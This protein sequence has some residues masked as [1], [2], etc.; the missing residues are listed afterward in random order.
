MK[1]HIYKKTKVIEM[2]TMKK[3]SKLFYGYV[4]QL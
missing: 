1:I 2:A 4:A 3:Y